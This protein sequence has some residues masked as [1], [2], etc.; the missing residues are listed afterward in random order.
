MNRTVIVPEEIRD[1]IRGC[2]LN[3]HVLLSLYNQ[4]HNDFSERYSTS[5][6]RRVSGRDDFQYR[7]IVRISDGGEMHQFVFLINDTIA[8]DRLIIEDLHHLKK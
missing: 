2:G 5:R 8:Q 1:L 4:I 3:R 6:S 7:E